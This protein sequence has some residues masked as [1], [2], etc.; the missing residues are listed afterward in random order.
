MGHFL[1]FIFY[2]QNEKKKKGGERGREEK[3]NE[4]QNTCLLESKPFVSKKHNHC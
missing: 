1:C 3:R 4:E 2:N